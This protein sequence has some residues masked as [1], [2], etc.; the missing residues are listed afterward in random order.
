MKGRIVIATWTILVFSALRVAFPAEDQPHAASSYHWSAVDL[1]V[2]DG[3]DGKPAKVD[4]Q[5]TPAARFDSARKTCVDLTSRFSWGTLS[6]PLTLRIVFQPTRLPREK[7]PLVSKWRMVP[8]GRSFELGV[9][10]D[11][12]PFFDV[13]ASGDWDKDARE[14]V[15]ACRILPERTYCMAAIFD[16]ASRMSLIVN[17]QMVGSL[18][19]DVPERLHANDTR[20]LLGAQPPGK[21]WADVAIVQLVV[22]RRALS[23]REIEVWTQSLE[24]TK[25]PTLVKSPVTNGSMDL[26]FVRQQV[27]EYC[28]S[29]QVENQPYGVVRNRDLPEAPATLYASCDVAW[30]R[31][32]M[33][34]ELSE[35]LAPSQRRQWIDYINSFARDDGAYVG[36]RHSLQHA[37]GMVIGALAVLG[38]RQKFPVTLYEEFDD[39]DEIEPWLENV[40]WERQWGAS[41]LFWGGMHCYS[42]S[43][44]CSDAWR[45]RVFHWL[46]DNLD[47]TTGWWRRGVPQAGRHIEVLGGAAHIWPIYQHHQRRF[48]HPRQVIDSILAMQQPDGSWLGFGNYMEL[49]AL[50]G[51]AYMHSLAPDHRPGDI[52]AAACRHGRLMQQ[53]YAGF[54][55]AAPNAHL[56]LAVVGTLALLQ[57]LD[58][59]HFQDDVRW[60]DIF[61]DRLF[62][63]TD[64]V[65]CVAVQ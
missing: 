29:L 33:G 34:E 15:G 59:N 50:Y 54:L 47:P 64:R 28:S 46:D 6:G 62:Y 61:S 23:A 9:M 35:T 41:H 45:E 13:S 32:C 24:L 4:I 21:R 26:S 63:R 56:L 55:S 58:P 3:D 22:D 16:S 53:Y 19:A 57:E 31:A 40:R 1:T 11:G 48:P 38:G 25:L 8:G 39:V 51:L 49:D 44:R 2:S 17:G 10:T 43:D 60:S 65:E 52:S 7:T 12:R 5:G 27:L 30:I 36:G 20:V 14:L 37:N 42:L 18:Q